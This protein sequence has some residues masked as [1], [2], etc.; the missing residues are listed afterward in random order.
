MEPA[1]LNQILAMFDKPIL[2][3][4]AHPT[5]VNVQLHNPEL[6]PAKPKETLTKPQAAPKT[7]IKPAKEFKEPDKDPKVQVQDAACNGFYSKEEKKQREVEFKVKRYKN[8][9]L[10]MRYQPE[11]WRNMERQVEVLIDNVRKER[12]LSRTWI[13][14]DMDMFFAACEIHDNPELATQPVAVGDM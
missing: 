8:K 13:H 7:Y 2:P 10:S 6:E 5:S 3:L 11:K 4:G 1:R 12:I 9:V 14:V